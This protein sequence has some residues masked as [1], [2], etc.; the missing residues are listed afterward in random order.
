MREGDSV[1]R[2]ILD[3]CDDPIVPKRVL[4][5]V[6]SDACACYALKRGCTVFEGGRS[7]ADQCV[8]KASSRLF[9][10]NSTAGTRQPRVQPE[11]IGHCTS[12]TVWH[13]TTTRAT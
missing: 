10:R 13:T 6:P 11:D 8:L 12:R 9:T 3:Y 4:R 7:V 1:I 5:V 2:E